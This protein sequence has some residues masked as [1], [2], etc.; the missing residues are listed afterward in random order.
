VTPLR[1]RQQPEFWSEKELRW[2]QSEGDADP[3]RWEHAR[4]SL[5]S[6]FHELAREE[7]EP[8]DR[9]AYCEGSLGETGRATIDHFF[10]RTPFRSLSLAW[11]NLFPACD[12]CNSTY[13]RDQYS[14]R[15]LKP[16]EDA[17]DRFFEF[18]PLT[19]R[20]DP[21]PALSRRDQARARVTA[22]VFGLN[23]PGR[24]HARKQTVRDLSNAAKAEDGSRL[25]EC[26]THGPYRF[27][28]RW[29]LRSLEA[30]ASV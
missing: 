17:V 24:C 16:D 29:Y 5:A 13:K 14:C 11:A 25:V 30:P 8:A 22:R 15:L 10:P 23:A 27:V 6:W 20:I 2:L 18:D 7:G 4:R 19:G 21:H 3:L 28:G 1:R 26:A 12:R 9:C